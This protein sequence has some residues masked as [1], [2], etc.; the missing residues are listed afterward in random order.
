MLAASLE[1][2][3]GRLGISR[4]KGFFK[5]PRQP[6]SR[7]QDKGGLEGLLSRL[8]RLFKAFY[9]R[10]FKTAKTT[11]TCGLQKG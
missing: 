7:P 4:M 5:A 2:L 11:L 1:S 6:E 8:E 3:F 9:I 10:A